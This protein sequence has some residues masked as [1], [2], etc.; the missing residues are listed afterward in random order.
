MLKVEAT[1]V[2]IINTNALSSDTTALLAMKAQCEEYVSSAGSSFSKPSALGHLLPRAQ[3]AGAGQQ[4]R[5]APQP[6][7]L[8]CLCKRG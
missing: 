6:C 4:P 2:K 5:A 7:C 1:S 3:Y 8:R